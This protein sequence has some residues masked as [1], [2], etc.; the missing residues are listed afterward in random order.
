MRAA[1]AYSLSGDRAGARRLGERFAEMMDATDQAAAF[2]LLTNDNATPGNVRF[3]DLA[4]RIAGID[5]LEAFIAP[6]RARFNGEG[7]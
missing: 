4:G 1:I 5:T 6:F 7:A 2:A 3:N